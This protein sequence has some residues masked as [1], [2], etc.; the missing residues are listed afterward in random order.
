MAGFTLSRRLAAGLEPFR[1]CWL[2]LPG[3]ELAREMARGFD[4]ALIDLQHGLP[5]W[6]ETVAMIGAVRAAGKVAMVRP[7]LDD[8]ATAARALDAGAEAIVFPM[9]NSPA[10]AARLVA[11]TKYPPLGQRSFGPVLAAEAAGLT[12]AAY[13]AEA[14]GLTRIFAM[15]ETAEALEN[16]EAIAATPG[17]DGLFVGPYDLSISL[18]RGAEAGGDHP[19]LVTALPRIAAAAAA[20]GLVPGIYASTAAQARRYAGLGFRFIS[21]A[22]DTGIIAAGA[23]AVQA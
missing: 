21:V 7:P 12:D 14:N 18:S 17:L 16:V 13:L 3:A 19:G 20:A 10:D 1:F 4:G 23:A 6:A 15:I 11:A 22:S 2:T 5:G 8:V 9:V